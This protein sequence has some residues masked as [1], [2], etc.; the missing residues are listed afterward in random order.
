MFIKKLHLK[1]TVL[2]LSLFALLTHSEIF[3][4]PHNRCHRMHNRQPEINV[5][6]AQANYQDENT[7]IPVVDQP[8]PFSEKNFKTNFAV[9]TDHTLFKIL[10]P[11]LYSIDSFLLINVPNIGDTVGGFITINGR[12]ILTFF[13]SETRTAS[14]IV[15]FHFN[16]RLVY[17]RKDDIVSVVLSE[18]TPGTTVLARGLVIVALNNSTEP[19]LE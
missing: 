18:F 4:I 5:K 6:P 9:S 1:T 14:P 15:N 13:N 11:G 2:A 19:S 17:L 8:I 3:A 7:F 10:V 12:K 16:D